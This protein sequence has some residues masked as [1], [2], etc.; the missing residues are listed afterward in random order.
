[1]HLAARSLRL[2]PFLVA[3]LLLALIVAFVRAIPAMADT[4]AVTW[5]KQ[6]PLI[7]ATLTSPAQTF[8][9]SEVMSN[10]SDPAG[11]GGFTFTVVY[12][13]AIWQAPAIDLTPAVALFS[14]AGR[15]LSC[16]QAGSS[17]NSIQM[18]CAST[19]PIGS[20]PM[21]TGPLVMGSATLEL[22]PN[23]ANEILT[24][25]NGGLTTTV[26]DTVVQVTNTC[27]QPLNDGTIQP[28]PGQPEC[29]GIVLPGLSA[30]GVVL[31]PGNTTVTINPP[32]GPTPT[33]T[34]SPTQ[35]P[36]A[37]RTASPH[38]TQ[39]ST[40]IPTITRTPR[41]TETAL[42]AT[43]VPRTST[44]VPSSTHAPTTPTP[45]A[46]HVASTATAQATATAG[47]AGATPTAPP[48]RHDYHYW[49]DHPDA[50]ATST[51]QLGSTTYAKADLLAILSNSTA[52]DA[53][54]VLGRELIA[55]KLN[56]AQGSPMQT[57][58]LIVQ[59]DGLLATAGSH[60]PFNLNAAAPAD[61]LAQGMIWTAALLARNNQDC[62]GAVS[63]SAVTPTSGV[64]GSGNEGKGAKALPDTGA[65]LR[66]LED[67]STATVITGLCLIIVILTAALVR[68]TL[69]DREGD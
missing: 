49:H 46:T 6:P 36:Q 44:A 7:S 59:A 66:L 13:A 37:T 2:R 60:L 14:T 68:L 9:F 5:N 23:V 64:L 22:L 4:P 10:Q 58:D 57:A 1:M 3:F 53:S 54:V 43:S 48:C 42:S 19:G 52:S 8:V 34:S 65:P 61:Y 56:L 20:G 32:P 12:D 30:S 50:W 33:K 16:W 17:S 31:S 67:S 35:T 21:W 55:G 24:D 45:A 11:L 62:T 69:L 39:T 47:A 27:G 38:P 63:P 41:S 25:G 40:R 26:R 29:Q 15:T 51:V 28:V 18:V